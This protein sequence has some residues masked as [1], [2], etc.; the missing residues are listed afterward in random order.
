MYALGPRDAPH[1]CHA[2]EIDWPRARK[3]KEHRVYPMASNDDMR[4][5]EPETLHRSRADCIHH[6]APD[7]QHHGDAFVRVPEHP[8]LARQFPDQP[9]EESVFGVHV[10]ERRIIRADI[11]QD[12]IKE[13]QETRHPPLPLFL[14]ERKHFYI[15]WKLM[16]PFPQADHDDRFAVFGKFLYQPVAEPQYRGTGIY[17]LRAYK[18]AHMKN[19]SCGYAFADA[20]ISAQYFS[21][22]SPKSR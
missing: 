14:P 6:S 13:P 22:Y 12:V 1:C 7:T 10:N 21:T 3:R 17:S 8:A 9:T 11:P 4:P 2:Q 16:I 20:L 5:L 15:R 18:K 19:V